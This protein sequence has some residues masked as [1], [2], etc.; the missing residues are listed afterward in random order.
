[1]CSLRLRLRLHQVSADVAIVTARLIPFVP[2]SGK[3]SHLPQSLRRIPSTKVFPRPALLPAM[4]DSETPAPETP[5][6]TLV[7]ISSIPKETQVECRIDDAT[8]SA[9]LEDISI[10]TGHNRP[11]SHS[12]CIT[13]PAERKL[14]K[15][16]ADDD[17]EREKTFAQLA[18]E[19][20]HLAL[21]KL[22][23]DKTKFRRPS[24]YFAEM[25]KTDDHMAKV[26]AKIVFH[27]ER[28]EAVQKQRNNR[29]IKKNKKK[30]RAEQMEREVEKKRQ[31]KGEVKAIERLRKQ[32]VRQRADEQMND[33]DD[34]FPIDLLDVEQLDS[35]SRFQSQKDIAAGK[36]KAW[37]PDNPTKKN[38]PRGSKK[39]PGKANRMKKRG[40]ANANAHANAKMKPVGGVR[41]KRKGSGRAK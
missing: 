10:F 20:T 41:K 38:A 5:V 39:R 36:K 37:K 32:R 18:T 17:L 24:D 28:I 25:V 11:F 30:M 14:K 23:S 16:L 35:D 9:K 21:A 4:S 2:F 1:M 31:A 40:K 26:K 19:A 34:E 15:A 3:P 13:L 6:V 8:I 7:P 29:D 33:S 12:L 22:R 27:K